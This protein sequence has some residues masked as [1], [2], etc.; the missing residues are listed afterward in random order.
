[1]VIEPLFQRNWMDELILYPYDGL[2]YFDYDVAEPD[3]VDISSL[4]SL[5]QTAFGLL[6][7]CV[8]NQNRG[9]IVTGLGLLIIGVL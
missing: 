3:Q 5:M 1:M 8:A 2:C 4:D 7:S 9:G 6:S